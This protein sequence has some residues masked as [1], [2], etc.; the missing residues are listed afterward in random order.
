MR[1]IAT[2]AM[3]GTLASTALAGN[4]GMFVIE[5][6]EGNRSLHKQMLQDGRCLSLYAQLTEAR[7]RG[8]PVI[9]TFTDPKVTG[10]VVSLTCIRPDGTIGGDVPQ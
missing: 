3:M 2:I 4:L 7:K 8:K 9:R 10:D 6:R 5:D 1:R